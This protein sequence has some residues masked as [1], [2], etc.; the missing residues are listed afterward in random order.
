MLLINC[1]TDVQQ[2]RLKHLTVKQMS[3]VLTIPTFQEQWRR[4]GLF[5]GF[6]IMSITKHTALQQY[7]QLL[8]IVLIV[9]TIFFL[10]LLAIIIK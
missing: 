1:K 6:K 5:R 10:L 2:R 7:R 4:L 8:K 9:S 3:T